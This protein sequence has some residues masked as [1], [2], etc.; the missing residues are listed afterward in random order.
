[1]STFGLIGFPLGHSFSRAWFTKKFEELGLDHRYELFP[2]TS[3]EELPALLQSVPDL[4]GL[5][6][7]IPYKQSVLPFLD[8]C[9]EQALKIG[10]VNTLRIA[11][12]NGKIHLT[13]YNS[14][15]FGFRES[16]LELIGP[17]EG[18]K[19]LV[20]GNGGSSQTVQYVL[21][22]LG[23]DFQVVSRTKSVSGLTYS[24]LSVEMVG[25]HPL[26]INTTPLGMFPEVQQLPDLPYNAI[27]NGHYLFDLVYNPELTSFLAAGQERGARIKNGLSMLYTQ[28]EYSWKFWNEF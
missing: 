4:K 6:V 28:A 17:Q 5:N 16:L 10:A 2:L 14:D 22:E 26:I 18:L 9:S 25:K 20:L 15:Y 1:M 24:D 23:I 13:G 21:A 3:I 12:K 27:G 11:R 8:E 19:A 7:T